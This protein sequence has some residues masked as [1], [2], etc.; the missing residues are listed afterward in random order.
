MLYW[1]ATQNNQRMRA[2]ESSIDRSA[3]AS[4]LLLVSLG[5]LDAVIKDQAGK[6]LS[7]IDDKQKANERSGN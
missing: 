5:H 7:E 6:L 2:V 3:K 4:L 1:F